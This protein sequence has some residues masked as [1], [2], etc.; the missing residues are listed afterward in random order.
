MPAPPDYFPF[1]VTLP[2]LEDLDAVVEILRPLKMGSVIP[3]TVAISHAA[4]DAAASGERREEWIKDGE[5]HPAKL[6]EKGLGVW[7][8]YAALYGGR[9]NIDLTWQTTE[10]ALRSIAGAG[11]YT[12]EQRGDDPV[13][14]SWVEGICHRPW[15]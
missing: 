12:A 9:D 3:N 6:T 15:T 13:W 11:I 10:A 8:V 5:L 14:R 1:M 7:N 2:R 4:F